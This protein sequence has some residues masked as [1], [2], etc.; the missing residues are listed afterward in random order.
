MIKSK[1]K[2]HQHFLTSRCVVSIFENVTANE[3][4][5]RNVINR[6]MARTDGIMDFFD[7]RP[8]TMGSKNLKKARKQLA[9]IQSVYQDNLEYDILVFHKALMILVFNMSE[10]IP[11][12][13]KYTELNNHYRYLSM[14]MLTFFSH[15]E[16]AEEEEAYNWITFRKEKSEF[17]A[18]KIMKI[19]NGDV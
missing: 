2:A 4:K 8:S 1:Q 16:D 3:Q 9:L 19:I 14:I 7:Y 15:L 12:T 10:T 17:M 5:S 11:N 6:I 18:K 13:K